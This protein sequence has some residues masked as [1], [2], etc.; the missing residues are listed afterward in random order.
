MGEIKKG[1]EIEK[2]APSNSYMWCACDKCGKERWVVLKKDQ[3]IS[4]FC[5]SC[6][7]RFGFTNGKWTRPHGEKHHRW[8]GGRKYMKNGY[9][10]ITLQPDDFFLPMAGT[11]RRVLEHRL[12]MAKYLN[13]CLLP[14]EIIHHKNGIRNDNRIENLSLM[15]GRAAHSGFNILQ[16]NN[17]K[18][19][20]RILQLEQRIILLEADNALLKSQEVRN[21]C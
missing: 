15:K 7:L 6:S 4:P 1:R 14:W 20:K 11:D 3:P 8:K 18:L 19:E 21:E 12:V 9:I 5:K 2:S 10:M 17:M 13:R 16:R